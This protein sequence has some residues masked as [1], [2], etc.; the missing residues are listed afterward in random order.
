MFA[1]PLHEPLNATVQER[2][3][4]QPNRTF[5]IAHTLCAGAMENGGDAT[6]SN[7]IEI[8]EVRGGSQQQRRR[9]AFS[10]E[11]LYCRP[12][13]STSPHRTGPGDGAGPW[14]RVV[15]GD[16]QHCVELIVGVEG[17][18]SK[19]TSPCSALFYEQDLALLYGVAS[20]R[21]FLDPFAVLQ[22][23]GCF[24]ASAVQP[25]TPPSRARCCNTS[26]CL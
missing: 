20:E 23:S 21:L 3:T 12:C 19:G 18:G 17:R 10:S 7:F 2:L 15:Y 16:L 5:C 14:P 1:A 8:L 6:R 4:G 25:R 9:G 13:S 24:L 11:W 26:S 22:Q